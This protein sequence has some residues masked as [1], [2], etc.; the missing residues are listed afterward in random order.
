MNVTKEQAIE[1]INDC[2]NKLESVNSSDNYSVWERNTL[3]F[4]ARIYGQKSFQF[5]TLDQINYYGIICSGVDYS[6][7]YIGHKAQAKQILEGLLSE[8]EIFGIPPH[9]ENSSN[10]QN[11]V[12]VHQQQQQHQ[13][14]SQSIE[15]A[16]EQ[17]V[18]ELPEELI[19]RIQ[20][21]VKEGGPRTTMTQRIFEDLKN[22]EIGTAASVLSTILTNFYLGTMG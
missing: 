20:Q 10:V 1:A 9:T 12:N 5:Q 8:I 14:Q 21:I 19:E 6:R 11:Q 18:Q 2:I 22:L 7:D 3:V 16:I 4:L 15:R 13:R 17:A